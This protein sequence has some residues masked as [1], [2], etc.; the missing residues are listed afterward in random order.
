MSTRCKQRGATPVLKSRTQ[1]RVSSTE[2]RLEGRFN[3]REIIYDTEF[4]AIIKKRTR[5]LLQF[6][7]PKQ[8]RK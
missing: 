8:K 5:E 3:V 1:R 2:P 6:E 4:K 7:T